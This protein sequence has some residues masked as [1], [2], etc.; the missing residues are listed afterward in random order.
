MLFRS[1][2]YRRETEPLI[3]LYQDRGVLTGIPGT[4]SIDAIAKRVEEAVGA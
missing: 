2:V 4:G 3:A 1:D